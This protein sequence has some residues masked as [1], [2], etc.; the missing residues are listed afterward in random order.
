MRIFVQNWYFSNLCHQ[1]NSK[2]YILFVLFQTSPKLWI[3]VGTIKISCPWRHCTNYF[4]SKWKYLFKSGIFQI[5][6]IRLVQ[7]HIFCLSKFKHL[8]NY[9]LRLVPL[10]SAVH[11][12]TGPTIFAQSGNICS[13]L[14]FFKSVPS[15]SFKNIYFVCLSSNISKIIDWGWYYWSQLFMMSP[16]QLFWL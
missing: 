14:V 16:D 4:R 13:K 5:C 8:Q 9:R 11:D 15:D 6:A 12:V 7:K 2:T 3:E 1:T 10:K